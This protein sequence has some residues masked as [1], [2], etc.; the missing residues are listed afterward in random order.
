MDFVFCGGFEKAT[1][2]ELTAFI[3]GGLVLIFSKDGK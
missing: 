3:A 2:T 1:L